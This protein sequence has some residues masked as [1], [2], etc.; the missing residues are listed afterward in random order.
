MTT[1][2]PSSSGKKLGFFEKLFSKKK[3][4]EEITEPKKGPQDH[5]PVIPDSVFDS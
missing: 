4:K 1:F 2:E 5:I 3:P